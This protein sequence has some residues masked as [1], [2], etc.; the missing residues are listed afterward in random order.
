MKKTVH[1]VGAVIENEQQQILCA[2]RSATMSLANLW[3]F[4]GGKIEQ[5]ETPQQ[6]LKREIMEELSCTIDVFNQVADVTHEYE[7]VIVRLETYMAKVVAD[8]P[9]AS[10]HA[11]IR[12]LRRE[13]MPALQW[14]EA[15]IPT[16]HKLIQK[17]GD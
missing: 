3:E 9:I 14:A 11:Q 5:Q 17:E 15:D 6:A 16:L 4:P 1:V 7:N 8:E 10:E 12:W 13:E 2:Q